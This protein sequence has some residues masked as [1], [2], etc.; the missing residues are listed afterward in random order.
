[1]Q[2]VIER[3]AAGIS[4]S[5]RSTPRLGGARD[6]ARG[7]TAIREESHSPA[8]AVDADKELL[9]A[10][11]CLQAAIRHGVRTR[12]MPRGHDD[13]EVT[14]ASGVPEPCSRSARPREACGGRREYQ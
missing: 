9:R 2:D 11:V 5:P 13:P 14:G 6:L 10:D 1:M 4:S 7:R 8:F 12:L 3:A